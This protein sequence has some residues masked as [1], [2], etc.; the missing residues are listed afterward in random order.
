M[1]FEGT[2]EEVDV[3]RVRVRV[4]TP[5][6]VTPW[7]RV[8]VRNTLSNQDEWFPDE[9]EQVVGLLDERRESGCVLGAV[10]SAENKPT[11]PSQ[12][13]RRVR[14]SDSTVV[15]YDREASE[16]RITG[17][18]KVIV[19]A[20]VV[21]LSATEIEELIIA[22]GTSP[23]SRDDKTQQALSA[24]KDAISNAT[25]TPQDGGA[26]FQ[27]TLLAALAAWPPD[28]AAEKVTCD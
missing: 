12:D 14:F 16:L 7:L 8:V 21:Q 18:L 4:R 13:V 5:E 10:Y 25:P 3:E 1:F 23:P 22:G 19:S 6:E 27:T 17:D 28:T 26:G 20:A 9:G 2:V 15:E 24:L 11:E